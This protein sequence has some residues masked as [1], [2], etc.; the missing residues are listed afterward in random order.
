VETRGIE[1]SPSVLVPLPLVALASRNAVHFFMAPSRG[2]RFP[3]T[4]TKNTHSIFN[5]VG[6]F[7]LVETRGIEQSPSV[8]VPLP[9]VALT[10]RNA[11]H[12]FMASSRGLRFPFTKTKTT[13]SIFNTAGSF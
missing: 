11:V 8:L 3:F 12:F 2:V 5:T 13:R 1:Q 4:K 7:Y 9:L 6:I 10:S